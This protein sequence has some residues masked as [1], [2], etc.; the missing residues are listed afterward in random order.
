MR[1]PKIKI[2]FGSQENGEWAR[3]FKLLSDDLGIE[4]KTVNQ[5]RLAVA[6]APMELVEKDEINAELWQ[7]IAHHKYSSLTL[8][9]AGQALIRTAKQLSDETQE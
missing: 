9:E 6:G 1:L 4:I 2:K 3:R 8:N 5:Y 7:A